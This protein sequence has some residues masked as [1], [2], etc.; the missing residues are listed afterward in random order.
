MPFPEIFSGTFRP[1]TALTARRWRSPGM[2]KSTSGSPPES[3]CIRLGFPSPRFNLV[4]S[5]VVVKTKYA[6][7]KYEL[8]SCSS[9]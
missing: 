8:Q 4:H 7:S 9:T 3:Q 6:S 1:G 5:M 2:E